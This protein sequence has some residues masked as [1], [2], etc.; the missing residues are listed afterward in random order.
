V[1]AP[2]LTSARSARSGATG[3]VATTDHTSAERCGHV[4]SPELTFHESRARSQATRGSAGAH[5]NTEARSGGH[6]VAPEPTSARRCD[7]K[8]QL[9][10]Q[11]MDAHSAPYLDLKLICEGARSSGYRQTL[12][13]Q[14]ENR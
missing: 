9:M 13:I 6:V 5:L 8:I 11:H 12:L 4:T 3:H 2:E 10:W 7:P 1:A 14:G